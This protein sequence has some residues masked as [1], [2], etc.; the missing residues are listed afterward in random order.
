MNQVGGVMSDLDLIQAP[1]SCERSP[2]YP[3]SKCT[4]VVGE[5]FLML[6]DGTEN[7]RASHGIGT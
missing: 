5:F 7:K 4:N 3:P 6:G 1:F 2:Y